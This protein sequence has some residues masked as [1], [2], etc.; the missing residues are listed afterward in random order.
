MKLNLDYLYYVYFFY[1]KFF[2]KQNSFDDFHQSVCI[3]CNFSKSDLR[4]KGAEIKE[5]KMMKVNKSSLYNCSNLFIYLK[6]IHKFNANLTNK[7]SLMK[8]LFSDF[9]FLNNQ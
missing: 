5:K 7:N 2:G 4:R 9:S 1:F 3:L 6:N 8:F